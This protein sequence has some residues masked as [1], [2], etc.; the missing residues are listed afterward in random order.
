[1]NILNSKRGDECIGFTMFSFISKQFF[2]VEN[3][4][5]VLDI[6]YNILIIFKEFQTS[7]F[8]PHYC[9]LIHFSFHSESNIKYF[10]N[11]K[12]S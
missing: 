5:Q 2:T 1:M 8:L 11:I 4:I 6:Y 9:K 3:L 12:I 10:L 7:L